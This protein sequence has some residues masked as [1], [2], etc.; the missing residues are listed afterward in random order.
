MIPA[1]EEADILNV[2]ALTVLNLSDQGYGIVQSSD[3]ETAHSR[4]KT[5]GKTSITPTISPDSNDFTSDAATAVFLRYEEKYCAGVLLRCDRF[6]AGNPGDFLARSLMRQY[7]VPQRD[8]EIKSSGAPLM[9]QMS[10]TLVYM[11]DLYFAPEYR[12]KLSVLQGYIRAMQIIAFM[13]WRFDWAYAFLRERDVLRGASARYGFTRI[14]SNVQIW[15]NPP[16]GRSSTEYLAAV[17]K[18]EFL[19]GLIEWPSFHSEESSN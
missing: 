18:A 17:P 19:H 1:V 8:T 6:T 16:E 4:L 3:L 14:A 2:Y 15:S 13:K 11:G 9:D 5:L 12:G 10:G 7:R